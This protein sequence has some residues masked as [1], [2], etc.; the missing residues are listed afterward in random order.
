[1][2][3]IAHDLR[4]PVQAIELYAAALVRRV[5]TAETQGI[6]AKILRAA[7]DARAQIARLAVAFPTDD[8]GYVPVALAEARVLLV[9]EDAAVVRHVTDILQPKVAQLR[10]SSGHASSLAMARERVDLIVEHVGLGDPRLGIAAAVAH[11]GRAAALV[12]MDQPDE[13][14][15]VELSA[16]G[17]EHFTHGPGEEE[18]LVAAERALQRRVI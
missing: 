16:S 10:S 17:I 1:M 4:Q 15:S 2:R 5:D 12:L 11:R 13:A 14:A 7:A 18:C 9:G 3:N 8:T 6:V